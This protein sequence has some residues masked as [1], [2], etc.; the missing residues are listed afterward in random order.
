MKQNQSTR[1]SVVTLN[2][3]ARILQMESRSVSLSTCCHF[4]DKAVHTDLQ[5]TGF[6]ISKAHSST[7]LSGILVKWVVESE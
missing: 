2:T 7:T 6:Q 1:W 5:T 3:E 4:A